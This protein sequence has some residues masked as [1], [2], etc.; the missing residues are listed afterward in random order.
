MRR[1]RASVIAI[2]LG[3]SISLAALIA[4]LPGARHDSKSSIDIPKEQPPRSAV[5]VP[6]TCVTYGPFDRSGIPLRDFGGDIGIVYHPL[7]VAELGGCY[8]SLFISSKEEK[9]LRGLRRMADWLVDNLSDRGYWNYHFASSYGGVLIE[10]PWVSAVAQGYGA[11]TLLKAAAST[12]DVHY[13][14]AA[15]RALAAL[16][17]PVDD[18]GVRVDLAQGYFFE[19]VPG[20]RPT[21]ILNGNLTALQALHDYLAFE[22][23]SELMVLLQQGLIGLDYVVGRYD[24]GY[25]SR[26][27][28]LPPM[29]PKA[30]FLVVAV[31]R[32]KDRAIVF[33]SDTVALHFFGIP[34]RVNSGDF[35][36]ID[37]LSLDPALEYFE[38]ELRG[39]HTA[40]WSF[41]TAR[42]EVAEDVAAAYLTWPENQNV[43]I[44]LRVKLSSTKHSIIEIPGIHLGHAT[45]KSYHQKV[46]Q[47]LANLSASENKPNLMDVAKR[48]KRYEEE[49]LPLVR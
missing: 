5:P 7:V 3:L 1:P 23:D 32:H 12:G 48:W 13:R 41:P 49:R 29:E 28:L 4:V 19:E 21:H 20:K 9:Y 44:P 43:L 6:E 17:V 15:R 24:T 35:R 42:V 2:L 8:H 39:E 11:Q 26:Y 14:R 38:V 25:W 31:G 46:I 30:Q 33:P 16:R 37:N 34:A 47:Q 22:Q 36:R 40:A 10:P 18:G 27:D 45:G